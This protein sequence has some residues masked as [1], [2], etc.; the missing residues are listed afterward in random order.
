MAIAF[1]S[2]STS[3]SS[4]GVSSLTFSHTTAG[5]NRALVVSTFSHRAATHLPTHNSVTY[6][7]IPLVRSIQQV[8][9]NWWNLVNIWVLINPPLGTHNVVFSLTFQSASDTSSAHA[10]SFTGVQGTEGTPVGTSGI[11]T[12]ASLSITTLS[13]NSWVVDAG[14][15]SS[16]N[17]IVTE[18][19]G[20]T[21]RYFALDT[22]SAGHSACGSTKPIAT[23][24]GTTM[25]WTIVHTNW[26]LAAIVLRPLVLVG[27]TTLIT[28]DQRNFIAKITLIANNLG[29]LIEKITLAANDIIN[30][31]GKI[32]LATKDLRNFAGKTITTI[33]DI[34]GLAAAAAR[35]KA[36]VKE[37]KIRFRI[38]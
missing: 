7:G 26:G 20:Q 23:A 25:T 30:L 38:K 11:S 19:T 1:N 37:V 33:F 24:G 17:N 6:G 36:I 13:T 14:V 4:A 16:H 2:H 21:R 32:P 8:G 31:I 22:S 27:K 28:K 34:L 12:T 10:L 15:G 29:G 35:I 9:G 5:N 18:G 3:G